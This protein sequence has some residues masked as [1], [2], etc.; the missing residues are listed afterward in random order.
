MFDVNLLNKPGFQVSDGSLDEERSA[1]KVDKNNSS[2]K[3]EK[4]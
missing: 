4:Y 1:L 2:N 3:R